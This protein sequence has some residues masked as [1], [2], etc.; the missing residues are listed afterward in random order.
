MCLDVSKFFC[1]CY[2]WNTSPSVVPSMEVSCAL[3]CVAFHAPVYQGSYNGAPPPIWHLF[4]KLSSCIF[5]WDPEDYTRLRQ[6][7]KGRA[8]E[9]VQWNNTGR[10]V[11]HSSHNTSGMCQTLPFTDTARWANQG[12]HRQTAPGIMGPD[13]HGRTAGHMYGRRSRNTSDAC[14]IPQR[15]TSTRRQGP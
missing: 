6:G 8:E 3:G 1:A 15:S 2:R 12:Q 5:V 11:D 14:R 9:E 4:S 10:A 13:E 7:K